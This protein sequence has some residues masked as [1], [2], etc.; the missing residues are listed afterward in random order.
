M[1]ADGSFYISIKEKFNNNK[2][3]LTCTKLINITQNTVSL[4]VMEEI[5]KFLGFGSLL[6]NKDKSFCRI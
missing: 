2:Q 4:I 1:N 5:N 3:Y 6:I